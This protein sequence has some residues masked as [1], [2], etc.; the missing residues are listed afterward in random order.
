MPVVR[1]CCQL[2]LASAC[3]ACSVPC[4]QC[5]S[6]VGQHG[7]TGSDPEL[8]CCCMNCD[9]VDVHKCVLFIAVQACPEGT[10]LAPGG[11]KLSATCL[12][13]PESTTVGLIQG[14]KDCVC[15]AGSY[16]AAKAR[17]GTGFKPVECKVCTSLKTYTS[18]ED[19]A[20]ARC[21]VCGVGKVA[22]KSHTGE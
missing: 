18:V 13:C 16:R 14:K 6:H 5:F 10:D 12:T 8:T 1:V 15:P 21:S 22:N 19:N 17:P 4:K 2:I 20:L 11:T 9:A 3:P 7:F